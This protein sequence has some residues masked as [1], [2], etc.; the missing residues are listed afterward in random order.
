VV[1]LKV[2]AVAVLLPLSFC[3]ALP[4]GINDLKAATWAWTY[5]QLPHPDGTDRIALRSGIDKLSNGDNCDF[6]VLEART[7]AAEEEDSIRLFYSSRWPRS[8]PYS[9]QIRPDFMNGDDDAYKFGPFRSFTSTFSA[10]I[11]A[12]T[13]FYRDTSRWKTILLW[14][15]GAAFSRAAQG[16]KEDRIS[17][18]AAFRTDK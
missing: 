10:F 5:S 17:I 9:A 6:I 8:E 7:Y 15:T 16:S 14:W 12:H 4:R 13:T 1:L 3:V 18:I 11:L 2:L